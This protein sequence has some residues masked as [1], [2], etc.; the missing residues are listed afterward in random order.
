[1]ETQGAA[2]EAEARRKKAVDALSGAADALLSRGHEDVYEAEREVLM[3]LYKREAGE[4]W[5]EPVEAGAESGAAGS[6]S[7]QPSGWPL[8]IRSMPIPSKMPPTR[9]PMT[10]AATPS[11]MIS[12]RLIMALLGRRPGNV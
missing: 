3:R 8:T 2:D 11:Q 4:D 9:E 1:M 6:S 10:P 7:S 12:L 5:V